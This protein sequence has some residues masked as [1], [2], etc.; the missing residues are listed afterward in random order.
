M[1][2]G[3]GL[4]CNHHLLASARAKPGAEPRPEAAENRRCRQPRPTP[5]LRPSPRHNPGPERRFS[6]Q[7]QA[8]REGIHCISSDNVYQPS[9]FPHLPSFTSFASKKPSKPPRKWQQGPE[10]PRWGS[11][12]VEPWLSVT[13]PC[14]L[15]QLLASPFPRACACVCTSVVYVHTPLPVFRKVP[16]QWTCGQ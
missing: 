7:A 3:P 6:P 16:T 10:G 1:R 11:H 2:E 14:P 15:T 4:W 5:A 8:A 12:P 13:L 9:A